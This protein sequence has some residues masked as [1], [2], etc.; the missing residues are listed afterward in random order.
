MRINNIYDKGYESGVHY[1]DAMADSIAVGQDVGQTEPQWLNADDMADTAQ[2]PVYLINNII[3]ARTHGLI[4]GSSQSFKSFCVLKMAHSI[5]TGHD[6]FNHDIFMT[7]K[8][9]YICGEGI[10]ALGR[11]IKALKIV[12]G[13]FKRERITFPAHD[14]LKS[15]MHESTI[16]MIAASDILNGVEVSKAD[17]S[18]IELAHN[19][20]SAAVQCASQ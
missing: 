18:R 15:I 3:E 20:L 6:F 14:I 8:V 11:R 7:G 4:A 16:V 5:C 13:G 2:A 9:L 12:E 19:R 17:F 1:L 10:G